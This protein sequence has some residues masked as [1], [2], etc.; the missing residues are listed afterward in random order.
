MVLSLC[1]KEPAKTID[2]LAEKTKSE[3]GKKRT[4]KT[5]LEKDRRALFRSV[6]SMFE[7]V[8]RMIDDARPRYNEISLELEKATFKVFEI[9]CANPTYCFRPY[10]K[11][12]L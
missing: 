5:K 2:S 8:S 1:V 11:S 12:C 3:P 9:H 6:D 7:R 4:G 10:T